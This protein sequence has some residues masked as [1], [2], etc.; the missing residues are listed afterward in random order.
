[1]KP[2]ATTS[3][4]DRALWHLDQ[5]DALMRGGEYARHPLACQLHLD[6]AQARATLATID[7]KE[8]P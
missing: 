5:A 7:H 1:M 3:N 6:A 4:Y 8:T 2:N